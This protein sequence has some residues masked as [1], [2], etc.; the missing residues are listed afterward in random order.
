MSIA[1]TPSSPPPRRHR[2]SVDDY[3]RM[4]EA[5]LFG[6]GERV[7]LI[8]GEII[9]MAP[10]GSS[11]SGIVNRL[12]RLF[13]AAIGERAIVS[14]RNPI[15]LP[16]HSEP[17]PDIA[18]LRPREDFYADATARA[19]DVLLAIEVADATLAYDRDVK[20]PLYARHGV[21]E[22]WSIDVGG[23]RVTRHD[24]PRD[25]RY[26]R[27]ETPADLRRLQPRH[28]EGVTLD[29]SSRF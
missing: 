10:I 23:A 15:V 3:H 4:G 9:D 22:T 7:E 12:T 1:E 19:G 2:L 11:H 20:L 28:V 24:A 29:L 13:V 27:T 17:E 5:G 16:E 21:P 6:P 18:V 25:G 8:D 14:V 26:G